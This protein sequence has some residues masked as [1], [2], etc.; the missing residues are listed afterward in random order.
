MT[1][2]L[3]AAPAEEAS[4]SSPYR[5]ATVILLIAITLA[6]LFVTSYIDA[7]GRPT[8]REL[9]IAV[10]GT[11]PEQDPVAR[12]LQQAT[13][14]G[15]TFLPYPT[16]AAA[17]DA[18]LHQR[19]YA[20][21]LLEP[22]RRVELQLSS[23][24]GSSVT[25]VLT[26]AASTVQTQTG[27]AI[28]LRDLHPLPATDPSGLAEFYLTLAATIL[29]F[30]TTFQLRANAKPLRLRAWLAFTGALAVVGS[31][32]LVT[33]TSRLL[34][35]PVPF[36]HTW[37]LLAMQMATASAFAATMAVLI[38]RW[39]LLPTWLLFVVL[40][41]TSSGGAVASPLLPEPLRTL[42]RVLPSGATVSA[43]RS[44]TYFSSTQPVEPTLVLAGWAVGTVALLL[45][46]CRV[47]GKSPG[48]E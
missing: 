22:G 25:R 9:S 48:E 39:A 37:G 38:G 32:V 35:V 41:N 18:V 16:Q 11:P 20:V 30:V 33:L 17:A 36:L 45:F 42:S 43:I 44:A 15:I 7:L 3:P 2:E 47:R 1:G 23:A 12:A 4:P 5:R 13:A 28:A 10:V 34:D 19:V 14:K 40:G 21:L 8:A 27:T 24:S 26:Q 31:L 29:G 6:G 46:A